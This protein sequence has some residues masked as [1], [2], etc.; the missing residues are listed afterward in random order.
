MIIFYHK[1]SG[2]SITICKQICEF[3]DFSHLITKEK[4]IGRCNIE[5]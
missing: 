2:K 3:Y 1:K 5:F 4:A